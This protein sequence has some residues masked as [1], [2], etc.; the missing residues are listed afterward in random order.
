[1][2]PFPPHLLT[3]PPLTP[4]GAPT[5]YQPNAQPVE[6]P[7]PSQRQMEAARLRRAEF[8]SRDGEDIFTERYGEIIV[9]HWSN[10][11]FEYGA[12]ETAGELP[13]DPIDLKVSE[14]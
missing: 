5:N 6:Q 7:S 11:R 2:T 14:P 4:Y 1:M 10:E 9:A 13:N 3:A 12:W 8:I